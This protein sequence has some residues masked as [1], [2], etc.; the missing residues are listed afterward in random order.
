MSKHGLQVSSAK[1]SISANLSNVAT[2]VDQKITRWPSGQGT[3]YSPAI[4]DHKAEIVQLRKTISDQ[5]AIMKTSTLRMKV[6]YGTV[7]EQQKAMYRSQVDGISTAEARL[8]FCESITKDDLALGEVRASSGFRVSDKGNHA[9][10]WALV[11]IKQ[12]RLGGNS[13]S[14]FTLA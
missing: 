8:S 12:A 3:V 7:N 11:N 2:G 5:K 9:L 4:A 14:Y 10:D 6:E 1:R 13:V